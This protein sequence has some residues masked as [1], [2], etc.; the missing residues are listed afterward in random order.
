MALLDTE[1]AAWES[2]QQIHDQFL[3]N[4][5]AVVVKELKPCCPCPIC[6]SREHPLPYHP[7]SPSGEITTAED[8]SI[9]QEDHA[10]AQN[11]YN[12]AKAALDALERT[13]TASRDKLQLTGSTADALTQTRKDQSAFSGAYDQADTLRSQAKAAADDVRELEQQLGTLQKEEPDLQRDLNDASEKYHRAQG[14]L[15]ALKNSMPAES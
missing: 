3:N 13:I 5:Y 11:A 7:A 9:A 4:E 2:Y 15:E 8:D 10:K 12:Q 6:G 14:E 1:K